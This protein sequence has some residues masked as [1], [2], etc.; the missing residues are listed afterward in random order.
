MM[1]NPNG[2]DMERHDME[3]LE[4][5]EK[6]CRE[7]DHLIRHLTEEMVTLCG[8]DVASREA[9][10][11]SESMSSSCVGHHDFLHSSLHSQSRAPF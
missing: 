8:P 6:S 7:M 3:R 5:L 11:P 2:E 10:N 4:R 1:D 9:T